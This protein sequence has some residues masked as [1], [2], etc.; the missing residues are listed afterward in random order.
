[1]KKILSVF[2]LLSGC[3]LGAGAV[4]WLPS[5]VITE[6]TVGNNGVKI[7]WTYDD[8]EE[9][10][11]HFQVIVYKMHKAT[12]A[13]KF[14]LAEADFSNLESKGTMQKHEERSAIWDFIPSCPGWWLKFPLYMQGGIGVDAAMYF[15]GSDNADIFGGSYVISP[16]YDLSH[17]TNSSIN[18]EA[19]L[20]NEATSVS[21]G[22]ALWAWNTNW[23]DPKNIDYKPVVGCDYHYSDLSS[24]SWADKAE[25]MT[26]PTTEG[27]TDPDLVDEI[28]AID[29][30]RSRVMFYG[31]GHSAYWLKGFKISVD[32]QPGDMVDYSASLHEV[33]GNTFTIDTSNDTPDDYVY[34]YE[35]RPVRME[36]DEFRDVTTVRMV[37][38]AYP[39]PRYIVG[40]F[41]GIGDI[42]ADNSDV[43]IFARDGKIV[44]C[45][46]EGLNAKVYN[47]AG[48]CVYDGSAEAEISLARGIYIVTAGETTAKVAL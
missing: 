45:G 4:A 25:T 24:Y 38:Y 1:M 5:A 26:F 37:N 41:A 18:V 27:V 40:N 15:A 33:V 9:R 32:M 13:E 46:A 36:Y 16:D 10:C 47:V 34:A 8:S 22:F 23:F 20:A 30:S 12:K 43:K 2:A 31:R 29:K 42:S 7:S 44:I 28:E 11:D 19:S 21:G 14:V 6:E 3:A 35:V 48:E 17:L 39:T